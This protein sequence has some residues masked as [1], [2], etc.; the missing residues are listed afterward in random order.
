MVES[1]KEV[2]PYRTTEKGPAGRQNSMD[3][4]VQKPETARPSTGGSQ[5][6]TVND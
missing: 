3:E 6:Q 1:S 2:F 5:S 4:E